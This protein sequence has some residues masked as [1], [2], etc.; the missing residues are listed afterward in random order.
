MKLAMKKLFSG[1]KLSQIRDRSTETVFDNKDNKT[2]HKDEMGKKPTILP[3]P[4]NVKLTVRYWIEGRPI[5]YWKDV[6]AST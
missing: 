3:F 2:Y 5:V 6:L 4:F 1:C